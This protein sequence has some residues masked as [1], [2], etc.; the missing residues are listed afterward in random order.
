MEKKVSPEITV[1][2]GP[3]KVADSQTLHYSHMTVA[4]T[5]DN[6][7]VI[8]YADDDLF[9]LNRKNGKCKKKK[10]IIFV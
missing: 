1:S 2:T 8:K 7:T 4:C 5:Q 9:W 6:T 10:I 3:L